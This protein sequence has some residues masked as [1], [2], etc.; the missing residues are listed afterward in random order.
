MISDMHV[1]F[2]KKLLFAGC[3]DVVSVSIVG[4]WFLKKKY[5]FGQ[6]Y[7]RLNIGRAGRRQKHA[8]K[9]GRL[10]EISGLIVWCKIEFLKRLN[11]FL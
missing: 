3:Y 4:N 2:W 9:E 8:G 1:M 6:Y 7:V 5:R 10:Q 11:E